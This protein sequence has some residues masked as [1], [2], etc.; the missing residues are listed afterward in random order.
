MLPIIT[1]AVT[2]FYISAIPLHIAFRLRVGP[3]S[4]FGI[5]I[6]AFE[7]RFALRKSLKKQPFNINLPP[8][9]KKPD[10]PDALS[11]AF[12]F[13]KYALT[14]IKIER[15]RL[16]GV[17]GCDDAALTALVCGGVTAVGNALRCSTGREIRFSLHP[18]FS[19][20]AFR[21]ELTGMI[22]MRLGHIML[23]A[24]LGA[25]QYGSRRLKE[26]TSIPL[27]AS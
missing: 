4:F 21:T 10:F 5:G 13:F 18:D 3:D 17:F 27:K 7:P 15:I 23:A 22:S 9:F 19:G 8:L 16:D 25:Y 12:R 6:S 11:S 20:G 14:H 1:A 26:W 2:L 24:L